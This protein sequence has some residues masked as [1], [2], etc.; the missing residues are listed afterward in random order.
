MVVDG[1]EDSRHLVQDICHKTSIQID[2]CALSSGI[3]A[4]ISLSLFKP[5]ILILDLILP[6]VNGWEIVKQVQLKHDYEKL[7]LITMSDLS[8]K[9]LIERGGPPAGTY[10]FKKPID[11]RWLQGFLMARIGQ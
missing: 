4:L 5:Q 6:G 11:V 1:D 8:E 9:E 2:C 10:F 3:E 7:K